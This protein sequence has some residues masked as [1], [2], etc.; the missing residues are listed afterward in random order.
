MEYI[1]D[2]LVKSIL[3]WTCLQSLEWVLMSAGKLRLKETGN[4]TFGFLGGGVDD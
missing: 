3:L 4:G 2:P 1:L